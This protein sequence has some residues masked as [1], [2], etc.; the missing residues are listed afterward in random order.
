V[1]LADGRQKGFRV[2]PGP[3]RNA[4]NKLGLRPGDLV[5]AINGTNLDDP[6]VGKDVFASLSTAATAKLSVVR[7]GRAQDV[8]IDIAQAVAEAERAVADA[9]QRAEAA[10]ATEPPP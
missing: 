4:F 6:S 2:F 10:Q 1:V 9:A 8:S 7:D 3:N 5:T